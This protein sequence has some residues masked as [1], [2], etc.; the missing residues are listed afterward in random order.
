V[1]ARKKDD[2]AFKKIWELTPLDRSGAKDIQ[3]YVDS[4]LACPFF[5][6][7]G[8]RDGDHYVQLILF[9]DAADADFFDQH[10]L[11]MISA[12]CRGFVDLLE[13]LLAR[14]A[15][16][17]VPTFY[18]GCKVDVDNELSTKIELL[19]GLGVEFIDTAD[20][21]WKAGLTFRALRS[22]ELEVS[23]FMKVGA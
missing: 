15:I 11:E 13:D 3:P 10:V 12:A 7:E 21:G 18:P 8:N 22:V 19:R 14:R 5:A 9:A 4:L 2:A 6:P 16:R 20:K 17:P 1:V 23:P